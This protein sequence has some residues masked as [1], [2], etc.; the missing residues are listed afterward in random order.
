[1]PTIINGLAL[2]EHPDLL[3]QMFKD[4]A[5]VFK[6]RLDWDVNVNS[7]GW[8]IDE[9]DYQQPVY[10][11]ST[12]DGITHQGSLR[13]LPTTGPHMMDGPFI[14]FFDTD[15]IRS[16]VIWECTRLCVPANTKKSSYEMKRATFDLL[17]ASCKL[18]IKIGIKQ[19][20]GIY[21]SKL[22]KIYKN[23]GWE[24]TQLASSTDIKGNEIKLGLWDVSDDVLLD[25][26]RKD[27]H[28]IKHDP[29]IGDLRARVA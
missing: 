12:N 8:E 7:D 11:I 19:F 5:A 6:D 9:Y 29:S 23:C 22:E 1:M 20:I 15:P 3:A 25:I 14:S 13:L 16:P 27:I 2:D 10:V 17:L 26:Y 24:P 21:E 4:R 18:G 28:L